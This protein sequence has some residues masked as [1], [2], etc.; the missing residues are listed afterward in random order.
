MAFLEKLERRLQRARQK[1]P[2]VDEALILVKDV[3]RRL[4]KRPSHGR[5]TS[6]KP[7]RES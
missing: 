2:V 6:T 3:H 7:K 1:H 5:Q 4:P